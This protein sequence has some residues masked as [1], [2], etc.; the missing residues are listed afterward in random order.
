MKVAKQNKNCFTITCSLLE[1]EFIRCGLYKASKDRNLC[2]EAE[3]QKALE[4]FETI[5]KLL[6]K[7]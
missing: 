1:A 3:R 6:E 7:E 2:L 4:A 5:D